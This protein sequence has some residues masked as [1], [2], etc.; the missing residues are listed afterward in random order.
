MRACLSVLVALVLVATP[1]GQQPLR[2]VPPATAGLAPEVLAEAT[3]LLDGFVADGRIA[4]GVVF[5]LGQFTYFASFFVG[6]QHVLKD[7]AT[8]T[9]SGGGMLGARPAQRA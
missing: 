5:L 2:T 1:S 9:I 4:G 8:P 3:A 7:S 6:G